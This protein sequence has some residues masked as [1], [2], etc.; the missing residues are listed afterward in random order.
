LLAGSRQLEGQT[1]KAPLTL[2]GAFTALNNS[3]VRYVG[4]AASANGA[5]GA[6]AEGIGALADNLDSVVNCVGVIAAAFGVRYVAALGAASAATLAKSAAD[7]RATQTAAALAAMQARLGPV[8]LGTAV[9]AN[10]AAASV[11]RVC[12]AGG[13]GAAHRRRQP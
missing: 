1:S 3:L 5:S 6:I 12:R 10:A 13:C 7:V 9:S 8:M 2:A 4:N 11:T